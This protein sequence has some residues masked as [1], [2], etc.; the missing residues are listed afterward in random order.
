MFQLEQWHKTSLGS[1]LKLAEQ[2]ALSQQLH[3]LFGYHLLLIGSD[4]IDLVSNSR[5]RHRA[6]LTKQIKKYQC[7][8]IGGKPEALPIMTDSMDV[9]ILFHSLDFTQDPHQVLR[10]AERVLMP[11]GHIIIIG[12]NPRS[13]WGLRKWMPLKRAN[14]PWR[15]K[16]VSANR[17]KDWLGLLG[18]DLVSNQ[19]LFYRPPVNH[20]GFLN[21]L[22]IF[23]NFGKKF[24]KL[25]GAVYVITAKKKVL[26][27]T[28]IKPR[29]RPQKKVA[30][31][32]IDTASR[33]AMKFESDADKPN[34]T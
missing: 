20:E 12:F 9:V 31:G 16:F 15:G 3:N 26:K 4:D 28:P 10:E 11:E 32:L 8:A 23:E 21:K 1:L 17:I 18:F 2:S 29:W 13:L 33:G 14:T 5:V 24:I 25:F 34:K 30:S 7:S 19:Q 27:L 6:I 22:N